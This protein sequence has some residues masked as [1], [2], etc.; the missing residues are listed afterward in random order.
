VDQEESDPAHQ[1]HIARPCLLSSFRVLASRQDAC[2]KAIGAF[3]GGFEY[4][5]EPFLTVSTAS[6]S[7]GNPDQVRDMTT[8]CQPRKPLSAADRILA[9]ATA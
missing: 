3:G 9:A 7:A 2:P 5:L 1:W 4:G 8:T 6:A